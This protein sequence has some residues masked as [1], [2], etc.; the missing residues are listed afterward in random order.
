MIV[1][2]ILI[3]EDELLI[4][5]DISNILENEGYNTVIGITTVEEAISAIT[6]EQYAL[7]LIDINL[8]DNTDGIALGSYLLKKDNLPFIYITS[9]SDNVTLDRIKDTRPHA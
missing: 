9:H 4:A 3:V 6:Q 5:K 2:K 1:P 7:V 8:S